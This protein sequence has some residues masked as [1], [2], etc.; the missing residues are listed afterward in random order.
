MVITFSQLGNQGRMGNQLWQMAA[1]M[2]LA[3]NHNDTYMFPPWPY[4]QYF[5]LHGCFSTNLPTTTTYGEP[6]F[7]YAP[8]PYK[9]NL[10]LSGYYQSYKYMLGHETFIKGVL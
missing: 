10:N 9:P 3:L 8:I 1:T 5:N 6:F 7:H 4:E 2:C